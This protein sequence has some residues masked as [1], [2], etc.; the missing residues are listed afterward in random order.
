MPTPT[1]A[2]ER[3]DA[4]DVATR[5]FVRAAAR[6]G[7]TQRELAPILGVSTASLS[8]V[9]GGQRL[10]DLHGKEGELALLF[11]RIYRSL[12]T[13]VGG[14]DARAEAWLRAENVHLGGVPLVLMARI[15][16]MFDVAGYLDG[17]RGRV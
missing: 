10:I 17:M 9:Q 1:L 4:A 6:V 16:G 2:L 3:P 5:A 15:Q 12:D 7:L 14:D 8:R 11:L 13:L